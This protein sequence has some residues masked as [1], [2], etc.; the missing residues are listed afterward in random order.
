MP[1]AALSQIA[2]TSLSGDQR[3]RRFCRFTGRRC[4]P[5]DGV[6]ER[7]S[8]LRVKSGE[9]RSKRIN[10]RFV[11]QNGLAEVHHAG[12][13]NV[14]ALAKL[15][16]IESS[17]AVSGT[18]R[19]QKERAVKRTAC[20]PHLRN[21]GHGASSKKRSDGLVDEDVQFGRYRRESA[22]HVRAV[23]GISDFGIQV[24]ELILVLDE[25]VGAM[26]QPSLNDRR[27]DRTHQIPFLSA[28]VR[29]GESQS[30]VK[31]SSSFSKVIDVPAISRLVMYE[32]TK[33]RVIFNPARWAI[34]V[35]LR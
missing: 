32:P 5:G 13:S 1:H 22:S 31:S 12:E 11:A 20:A 10:H 2:C 18:R 26:S 15:L 27:G 4:R 21:E 30:R 33:F 8:I 23:I 35:A 28:G 6:L 19:L 29:T 17:F 14:E 24:G 3:D 7:V 9:S 25:E 16:V 34:S